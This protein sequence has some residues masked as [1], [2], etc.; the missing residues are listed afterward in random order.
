ML[1]ISASAD[2]RSIKAATATVMGPLAYPF[3]AGS[4]GY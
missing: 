1:D 2:A 4:V 3:I